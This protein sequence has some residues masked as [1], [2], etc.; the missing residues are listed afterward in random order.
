MTAMNRPM[1]LAK[2]GNAK[3]FPDLSWDGKVTRK[4]ILIGRGVI[5]KAEGGGVMDMMPMQDV[6]RDVQ[7]IA[8]QS[9]QVGADLVVGQEAAIDAAQDPEQLINAI[10][11]NA[12][13]L[14]ARYNELA[15]FVGPE[16][17]AIT[18]TSVLAM[19]QP[20]IVMAS[21]GE[22]DQGIGGLIQGMT[23]DIMMDDAMGQATPMGM[24]VGELMAG[25]PPVAMKLGGDIGSM[26][27]E[28]ATSIE[29]LLGQTDEERALQQ[30]LIYG[31][32]IQPFVSLFTNRDAQGRPLEGN[33]AQK[34]AQVLAPAFQQVA[35]AAS[36]PLALKR[37]AAELGISDALARR[38]EQQ[39]YEAALGRAIAQSQAGGLSPSQL[40]AFLVSQAPEAIQARRDY[41]AGE[42]TA[43]TM[44]VDMALNQERRVM[45]R[46]DPLTG[47]L[48]QQVIGLPGTFQGLVDQRTASL[49]QT[50]GP[51]EEETEQEVVVADEEKP[52][53]ALQQAAADLPSMTG[54]PAVVDKFV[55]DVKKVFMLS[56]PS[57]EERNAAEAAVNEFN[58]RIILVLNGLSGLSDRTNRQFDLVAEVVPDINR[59]LTSRGDMF[60]AYQSIRERLQERLDTIATLKTAPAFEWDRGKQQQFAQA[61][62]ELGNLLTDLDAVLQGFSDDG[63]S[64]EGSFSEEELNLL[65]RGP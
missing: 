51:V 34:T 14:Q 64:L 44:L 16:D 29:G 53:S 38:R 48:T 52:Q 6:P 13:P 55:R 24:G 62:I 10:R 5:K 26:A 59:V 18:P 30:A 2:G 9:A 20:A 28:T 32:L 11:G 49:A 56:S 4:D 25:P 27:R 46:N 15:A 8:N 1:F 42:N 23:G 22:V 33:T 17:A 3:Q 36:G 12:L 31:N 47:E 58:N 37:K 35:Q 57:D 45:M 54:T 19:T 65:R 40:R 60:G 43:L 41:A 7:A 63:F 50:P 61:E 39:G 21:E